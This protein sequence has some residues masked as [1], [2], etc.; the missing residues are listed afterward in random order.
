[1]NGA[2]RRRRWSPVG[3]S[4]IVLRLGL[5]LVLLLESTAYSDE[6]DP[7]MPGPSVP[8][9]DLSV[10]APAV[11]QQLT[12][13]RSQ[14]DALL[15]RSSGAREQAMAFGDL[16]QLYLA[17]GLDS[18]ARVCFEQATR[19]DD[20]EFRWRYYLGAS[21]QTAGDDARAQ[22]ELSAVHNLRPGDLPTLLRLGEIQLRNHHLAEARRY[23]RLALE[24]HP[25]SAAARWGL[26]RVALEE[27]DREVAG[28]LLEEALALQPRADSI[29]SVLARLARRRGDLEAARHHLG[30]RGNGAVIFYDP[31]MIE[32]QRRTV[33]ADA[34]LGR[35]GDAQMQGLFDIAITE[36]RRAVDADPE[37]PAAHEA[38]ATVLMHQGE[39]ESAITEYRRALA[40]EERRPRGPLLPRSSA[41]PGR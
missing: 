7:S 28:T 18:A 12:A 8:H 33:G 9:P 35:G 31:L 23:F 3:R 40:L 24:A 15:A 30:L 21:Y 14:L 27:D 5:T 38:L 6:V 16:G 32:A 20:G 22:V 19:L 2:V 11:R 41:G 37:N 10:M 26:G 34:A 29:H 39:T 17:Y 4:S 36:Y 1:M 13:A 25:G